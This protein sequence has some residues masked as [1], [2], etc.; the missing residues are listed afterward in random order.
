MTGRPGGFES[1]F[2]EQVAGGIPQVLP[3]SG[4]D[5]GDRKTAFAHERTSLAFQQ[6]HVNCL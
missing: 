6:P 4:N 1:V 2:V 5:P 3:G